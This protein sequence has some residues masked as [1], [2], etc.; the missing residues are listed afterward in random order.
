VLIAIAVGAL[1]LAVIVKKIIGKIFVLLLAAAILFVGWQQRSAVIDFATKAQ[2]SACAS[3]P[4]FFGIDVSY[5]GC[6]ARTGVGSG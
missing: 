2:A 5:P 6:P 3:H 1:L 4:D